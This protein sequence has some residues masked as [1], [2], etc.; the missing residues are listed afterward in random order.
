[1]THGSPEHPPHNH[2]WTRDEFIFALDLYIRFAGNPL[3]K[4]SPEVV[5]LSALLNQIVGT[6]KGTDNRNANGVPST[7]NKERRDLRRA[8]SLKRKSGA[9]YQVIPNV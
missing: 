9:P 4:A 6:A 3:G 1:V 5:A 7:S 8:T 2:P